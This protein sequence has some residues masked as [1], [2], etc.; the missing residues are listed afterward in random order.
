MYAD[1]S[2]YMSLGGMSAGM[3][4]MA[5][6]ST[7]STGVRVGLTG[8]TL[9]QPL[10]AALSTGQTT[11]QASVSVIGLVTTAAKYCK[12]NDSCKPKFPILIYGLNHGELTDHVYDA[13]TGEGST[14]VPL[15]NVLKY[16][17][18][19]NSRT[20]LNKTSICN[21]QARNIHGKDADCDEYPFASSHQGGKTNS[22]SLRLIDPTDNRSG[23]RLLGGML[24]ADRTVAGRDSYIVLAHSM[25]P[26]SFYWTR[27]GKIGMS[28][29]IDPDM[30]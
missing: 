5:T 23:G 22:V 28:K 19:K 3:S 15:P 14:G 16:I 11:A 7:M 4:G 13:I 8:Q 17:K 26:L 21:T 2:G 6:L 27:K 29:G 18:P 1:P 25:V 10:I 30:E 12:N 9:I 24:R 20:W